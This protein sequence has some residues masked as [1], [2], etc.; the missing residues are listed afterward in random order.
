MKPALSIVFFTAASG[1]GLGLAMWL[2][3]AQLSGDVDASRP[4]AGWAAALAAL[5][6]VAGLLAS[7]Q[8]LAN[9]R[10]AWRAFARV[11][12]SWLSR[13]AVLAVVFWPLGALH[14]LLGVRGSPLV[15][16]SAVALLALSFAI[17]VSTAM[18]YACLKTVPRWRTWHTPA[19]FVACSL[20]SGGL[21]WAAVASSGGLPVPPA[22]LVLAP[23]LAA[24]LVK[25]AWEAK[26]AARGHATINEAL[27]VP[28]SAPRGHAQGRVRLLDAGHSH[29][30]FLTNEFGFVLAREREGALRIAMFGLLGPAAPLLAWALPGAVGAWLAALAF[31]AGVLLER[32]LFFARAEHVVRLYHGQPSV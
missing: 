32:W 4:G 15:A 17:V 8:H 2:L 21:L 30:T 24:V 5:L 6:I 7:T 18:I 14:L 19:G 27:A 1:A 23:V 26:F 22:A 31:A 28:L 13:E 11:R 10:N 9:P 12:T 3:A 25:L 29:G 20:G 16:A